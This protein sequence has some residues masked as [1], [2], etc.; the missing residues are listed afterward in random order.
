MENT[1]K[2]YLPGEHPWQSFLYV[3][4]SL[5]STNSTLKEMAQK[6]VPE[7][8]VVI[9]GKQ[10]AGR[11]RLGRSF[12]S[13]EDTGLYFSLLLRPNCKPEQLFHLTCACGAASCDA[14]RAATGIAP[15]IKWTNDI[16]YGTRK[17][18]GILT[19]IS[20]HSQTG[21]VDYAIVGIGINCLQKKEDFPEDIANMATSLA[22][23]SRAPVSRE[24]LAAALICSLCEMNKKLLTEL[25][26]L[27]AHY[28]A[29]C[30]TL[31]QD[32]MLLRG[33]ERKYGKALD[34][35]QMGRLL[36]VYPDGT[37]EAV[38]SGEVSVRGMYGYI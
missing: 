17:L 19:E 35:D 9:A 29:L 4:P 26:N 34:V 14:I 23:L 18:G 15:Q 7:G 1:I 11:G 12:Y 6:G 24:K 27:L 16:I 37:E 36:V 20:L 10:T 2:S 8:T 25:Q 31:G 22:I 28:K 30:A 5:P 21:L 13:P 33:D 32:I 3:Y 38:S